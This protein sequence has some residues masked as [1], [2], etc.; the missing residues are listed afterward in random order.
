MA[1]AIDILVED[2]L[3][4]AKTLHPDPSYPKTHQAAM[5]V[6]KGGSSCASCRF[7]SEDKKECSNEYYIKWNNGSKVLP[8]PADEYCSDWFESNVLQAGSAEGVWKE[9]ESRTRKMERF[10]VGKG[11]DHI[12]QG[13][14]GFIFPDGKSVQGTTHNSL[15]MMSDLDFDGVPSF[16]RETKAI[17]ILNDAGELTVQAYQKPTPEQLDEI[18][19][20]GR[21]KMHVYWA[22]GRH[23]GNGSIDD[24][25]QD[26]QAYGTSEGVTKAWDT[27]GRK[28]KV[29]MLPG[30]RKATGQDIEALA[31][32]RRIAARNEVGKGVR[33][34]V[35]KAANVADWIADDWKDEH[36]GS[37]TDKPSIY[38]VVD[39]PENGIVGAMNIRESGSSGYDHVSS[40]ATRP[41]VISGIVEERGVGTK[42]MLQAARY[43]ASRDHGLDLSSLSG[44]EGFYRKLGMQ[45]HPPSTRGGM[46]EFEWSPTQVKEMAK[47]V[48][49]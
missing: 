10:R 44:A 48:V 4:Y 43:A 28:E 36:S 46:S 13:F 20:L 41:D 14:A 32:W 33:A 24:L 9:W 18:R 17:R 6:P 40:L 29:G 7:V 21:G 49:Q 47:G 1:S 12:R 42:L 34:A 11:V 25:E 22:I 2:L 30:V 15:V 16:L 39:S 5:C 38:L 8:L 35:R 26:I 3:A 45:E 37:R 27:R 19:N 31:G 23:G